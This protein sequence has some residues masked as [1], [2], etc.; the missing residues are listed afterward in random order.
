VNRELIRWGLDGTE[1]TLDMDATQIVAEK[2]EARRTYK[3][4]RGYRPIVGHLGENGL[5]VGEEFRAGN[6]SPNTE[7]LEFIEHCASQLPEGARIAH[8]RSDSAAY[9]AR[10]VNWCEERGVSFAVGAALDAGVRASIEAIPQE[11]WRPYQGGSIA[12][13]VHSMNETEQAFR[14]VVISRPAQLDLFAKEEPG[15]RYTVMASNREE[16]AEETVAWYSQRG[17]A[18]ENRIKELKIGFGMER[19]PCGQQWANAMFF[20]IGVLA[21]NLFVL[22]KR[23]GLPQGWERHQVQT[24]RWRLYQTAGKVV[25]HARSV[26]LKIC[27]RMKELFEGVRRR[28][29]ELV[30]A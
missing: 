13:T 6:V 17:E 10:I 9:Q 25:E 22:F 14:L 1:Y 11:A 8:L 18:S 15:E 21:Y 16:T 26:S 7:D 19:M 12:E 3:G 28:C 2:Q 23:R 20:R 5:V 24:V 29:Y 30:T 27:R 4:E